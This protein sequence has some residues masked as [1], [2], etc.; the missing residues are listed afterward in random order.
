LHFGST[1]VHRRKKLVLSSLVLTAGFALTAAA[2]DTKTPSVSETIAQSAATFDE[3]KQLLKSR[4]DGKVVLAALP[5]LFAGEQRMGDFGVGDSGICWSHFAA[6]MEV[7]NR[8]PNLIGGPS[9]LGTKTSELNQLDDR[10]FGHLKQGPSVS[11]IQAGEPLRVSKFY[12]YPDYIA[13]VLST[14]GLEHWRD[15]DSHRTSVAGLGLEFVFYF[16]RGVIK[17][18]HNYADVLR[19]INKYL[20]PESAAQELGNTSKNVEIEPGMT[21]ELVIQKLGQPLQSIKFGD[22]KSLKYKGVTV[23]LKDGKVIDLK[24]D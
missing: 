2:Q 23:V 19:E 14:K 24:V 7:P 9:F 6:D 18:A 20:L 12:V 22:Q 16:N 1:D 17:E 11:P 8:V 15:V 5:G 3:L 13:F 10:T 4:Y 21:E